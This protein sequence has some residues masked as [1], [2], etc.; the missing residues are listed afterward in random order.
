MY[1]FNRTTLASRLE[2]HFSTMVEKFPEYA[3]ILTKYFK[4]DHLETEYEQALMYAR[5]AR[6]H[7]HDRDV[8]LLYQE[9][10]RLA[11]NHENQCQLESD[12]THQRTETLS[13]ATMSQTIPRWWKTSWIWEICGYPLI[14]Q[15][16]M[17]EAKLM[18]MRWRAWMSECPKPWI[19][20]TT[21]GKCFTCG[22]VVQL[23]KPGH[24][25][26]DEGF[27]HFRELKQKG[28]QRLP[29]AKSSVPKFQLKEALTTEKAP[30]LN[31][32]A[33]CC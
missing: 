23:P 20:Q 10:L 6:L 9:Y 16:V 14:L 33:K 5:E 26:K 25:K 30:F 19:N 29:N 8:K 13:R 2:T 28:V 17:L 1:L 31:P 18:A 21:T 32:D 7:S 3:G 12:A 27:K 4:T 11:W 24:P 22:E 15:R